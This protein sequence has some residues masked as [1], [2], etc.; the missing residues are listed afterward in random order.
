M[1]CSDS[2]CQ[3]LMTCKWDVS[4]ASLWCE[5]TWYPTPEIDKPVP[6][7]MEQ[8]KE[9]IN[10]ARQPRQYREEYYGRRRSRT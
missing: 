7:T 5:A 2:V 8:T 6:V 10:K 3:K 1:T 4:V 9:Q